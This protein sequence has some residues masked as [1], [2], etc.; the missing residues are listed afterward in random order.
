MLTFRILILVLV[1]SILFYTF[2]Q[3]LPES[4]R[5]DMACG[6]H[7]KALETLKRIAADNGKPMPLGRL[8]ETGGNVSSPSALSFQY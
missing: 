3:W 2:I 8:V 5:Y 7:T 1:L 6:N 4:V